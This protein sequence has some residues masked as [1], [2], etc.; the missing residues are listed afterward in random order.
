[1]EHQIKQVLQLG[2]IQ[3]Q[4]IQELLEQQILGIKVQLNVEIIQALLIL[5]RRGRSIG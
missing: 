1:L 4:E 3:I 2:T 5:H